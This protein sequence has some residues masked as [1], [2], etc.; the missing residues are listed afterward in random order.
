M[1]KYFMQKRIGRGEDFWACIFRCKF[2]LF[3]VVSK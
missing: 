2:Q 3:S 1:L